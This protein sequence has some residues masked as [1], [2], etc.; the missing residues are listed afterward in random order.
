MNF[1]ESESKSESGKGRLRDFFLVMTGSVALMTLTA[2]LNAEVFLEFF[3]EFLGSGTTL[4]LWL[5]ILAAGGISAF[6]VRKTVWRMKLNTALTLLVMYAVITGLAFS[7]LLL[8]VSWLKF[9]IAVLV[10]VSLSALWDKESALKLQGDS[11]RAAV[12]WSLATFLLIMTALVFW[13]FIW[14]SWDT[15]RRRFSGNKK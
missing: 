11:L 12:I 10:F 8:G 5:V 7:A 1:T 4:V 13:C 2:W 3:A 9:S 14:G 6:F 15:T